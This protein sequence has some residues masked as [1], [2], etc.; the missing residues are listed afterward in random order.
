M[1]WVPFETYKGERYQVQNEV[2]DEI[3]NMVT[4]NN[5]SSP[6][7]VHSVIFKHKD[8]ILK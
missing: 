6:V 4:N 7:Y 3:E 8:K 2:Q 5:I 1:I